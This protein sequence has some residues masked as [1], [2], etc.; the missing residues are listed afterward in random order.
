MLKIIGLYSKMS[1]EQ[2]VNRICEQND[3]CDA[4]SSIKLVEMKEK[5]NGA[6]AIIETDISSYENILKNGRLNID[7]E[8]CRVFPFVKITRCFKCQEYGHIAKYCK[9]SEHICGKCGEEHK[10]EE[11]T[12]KTIKCVNCEYAKD[13]LKINLDIDVRHYMPGASN[14]QSMNVN[15]RDY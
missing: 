3:S 7:F 11:C 14:V 6:T 1:E 9:K 2:L 5:S 12:S 15:K 10:S 8:R 4:S 13:V